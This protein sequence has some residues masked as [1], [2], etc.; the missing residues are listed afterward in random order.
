MVNAIS[1]YSC[2]LYETKIRCVVATPDISQHFL[3]PNKIN[4]VLFFLFLNL[5]WMKFM[6]SEWSIFGS[7]HWQSFID[8][9]QNSTSNKGKQHFVL[10]N[11]NEKHS[12]IIW[13]RDANYRVW[14]FRWIEQF[15]DFG[16]AMRFTFFPSTSTRCPIEYHWMNLKYFASRFLFDRFL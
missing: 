3:T 4:I 16:I 5:K 8:S 10:E 7:Y 15:F 14:L 1:H 12:R 2:E 11:W 9:I 13:M 6:K